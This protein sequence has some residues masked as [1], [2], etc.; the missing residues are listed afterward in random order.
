MISRF[1]PAFNK[2]LIKYAKPIRYRYI[3]NFPQRLSLLFNNY[4]PFS[5]QTSSDRILLEKADLIIRNSETF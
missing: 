2:Q 4:T 1:L 5:G 3:N